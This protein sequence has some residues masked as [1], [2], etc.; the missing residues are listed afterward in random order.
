ME[1]SILT[2]LCT[3]L[4]NI[5][6]KISDLRKGILKKSTEMSLVES[7]I[8][9]REAEIRKGISESTNEDGKKLYTNEEARKTEFIERSLSDDTYLNLKNQL[10]E[11]QD[12][13]EGEKI[14]IEKLNSQQRNYRTILGFFSK[15]TEEIS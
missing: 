12:E 7:D 15:E 3:D 9:V 10:K 11:M 6:G 5:P 4:L 1:H 2:D 13:L 8:I 14:D